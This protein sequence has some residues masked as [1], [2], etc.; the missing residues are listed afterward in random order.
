MVNKD[1]YIFQLSITILLYMLSW[2]LHSFSKFHLALLK[3]KKN[4]RISNIK[5]HNFYIFKRLSSQTIKLHHLFPIY[6]NEIDRLMF[7]QPQ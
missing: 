7:S 1:E 5:L 3:L 4:Y 6:N 2:K